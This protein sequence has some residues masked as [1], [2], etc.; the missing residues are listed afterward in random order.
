[1][2]VQRKQQGYLMVD[3]RAS[4]GLPEDVAIQAGMD[5]KQAGEGKFFEADTLTCAHCKAVVVKNPLRVRER[6][7]CPKCSHHYICDLCAIRSREPDYDHFP[8]DK[9]RDLSVAGYQMSQAIGVP[10]QLG[11]SPGLILPP[12]YV[13]EEIDPPVPDPLALAIDTA[14]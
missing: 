5:P 12:S 4:P 13:I 10:M 3:H 9:F 6:A 8:Y 14:A 7:N 1:M 11:S 2:S